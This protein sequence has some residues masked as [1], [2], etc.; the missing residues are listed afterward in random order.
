MK[1]LTHAKTQHAHAFSQFELTKNVLNNLSQFDIT[2]TAKLVLLYLTGCY[3]PDNADVFPKQSTIATSLGVSERSVVRAVQELCACGLVIIE[4]KNSN[5]YKFTSS[6]YDTAAGLQRYNKGCKRV[7]KGLQERVANTAKTNSAPAFSPAD[8]LTDDSGQ[9]GGLTGDKMSGTC[10]EQKNEKKT[11][12]AA[13]YCILCECL[14]YSA[15]GWM[16]SKQ[17]RR[18]S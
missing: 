8:K 6:V 12:Y 17:N 16:R 15:F 14:Y 2:P 7:A 11:I 13:Q 4:C 3:N 1:K 10:I 9:I 5:R 18:K